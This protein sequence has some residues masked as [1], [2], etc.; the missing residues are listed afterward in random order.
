MLILADA[1]GLGID[2]DELGERVLQSARDGD[3]AANGEI[4]VRKLLPRNFRRGVDAG[5]GFADSH[6]KDR[7]KLPRSQELAH[8]SIR[9]TRSGAIADGDGADVVLLQQ[10]FERPG[11]GLLFV[12]GNGAGE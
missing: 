7:V 9:L 10:R 2:L 12:L 1:D 6:G 8:K 3:G 5:A 11:G 4:Q